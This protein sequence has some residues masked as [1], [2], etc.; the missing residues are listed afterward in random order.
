MASPDP[1]ARRRTHFTLVTLAVA[2]ASILLFVYTLGTVGL[3]EIGDALRRLGPVGFLLVLLLS[4]A[5]FVARGAAWI[6]CQE[7][8]RRLRLRDVVAASPRLT[9]S[10]RVSAPELP[11]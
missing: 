7:G 10:I 9:A 8:E 2:V 1:I 4:G 5:R 6:T 11:A 3:A